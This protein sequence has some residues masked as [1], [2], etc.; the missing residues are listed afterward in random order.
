M[1]T[2]ILSVFVLLFLLAVSITLAA[3]T[4]GG[5]HLHPDVDS[6]GFMMQ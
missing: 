2:L 4:G 3:V 6:R 5:V 1:R